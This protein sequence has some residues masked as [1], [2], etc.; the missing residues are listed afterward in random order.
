M[1]TRRTFKNFHVEKIKYVQYVFSYFPRCF[2]IENPYMHICICSVLSHIYMHTVQNFYRQ[3]FKAFK[4]R[5]LAHAYL[6]RWTE[7]LLSKIYKHVRGSFSDLFRS[8][9]SIGIR[10]SVQ[11]EFSTRKISQKPTKEVTIRYAA[12]EN[13]LTKIHKK[14]IID[15]QRNLNRR[16]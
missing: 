15:L 11:F 2:K 10:Q 6:V 7:K 9:Q 12:S 5:S 4:S 8:I 3:V 14:Y 1:H 13:W 16:S